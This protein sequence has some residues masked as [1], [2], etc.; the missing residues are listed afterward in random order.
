MCGLSLASHRQRLCSEVLHCN[1]DGFSINNAFAGTFLFYFELDAVGPRF[2]REGS[3]HI[4]PRASPRP[5]GHCPT[6]P[7]AKTVQKTV[8]NCHKNDIRPWEARS[9]STQCLV[10]GSESVGW[11]LT[12]AYCLLALQNYCC[13][14]S[15]CRSFWVDHFM[16]HFR[17]KKFWSFVDHFGSIIWSII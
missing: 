15:T 8:G 2:F 3:R 17:G 14:T 1:I 16:D 11:P 4:P 9:M 6:L 7:F 12:P 5:M 10:G 13:V